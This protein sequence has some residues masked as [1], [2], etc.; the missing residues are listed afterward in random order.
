MRKLV[1][2]GLFLGLFVAADAAA[3]AFAAGKLSGRLASTFDLR[4]DPRVSIGG[5]PF[6]LQAA[7]GELAKVSIS[8]QELATGRISL[9]RVEIELNEVSFSATKAL[10]GE[11]ADARIGSGRGRARLSTGVL[12][13]ALAGVLGDVSVEGLPGMSVEGTT[14]SIGPATFELPVLVEGMAY[15]SA[16]L[17][18]GA[19]R[20]RFH[21]EGTRLRL[22]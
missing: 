5:F 15:D 17:V 12:E 21:L 11:L 19:V 3:R 1:V 22:N 9:D 18:D 20:L 6:L 4:E 16:R 8:T 2:I 7:R 14:L 13:D 10:T